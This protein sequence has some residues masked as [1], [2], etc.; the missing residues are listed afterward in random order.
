MTITLDEQMPLLPPA[1][2]SSIIGPSITTD[3]IDIRFND[4]KFAGH[5]I[6]GDFD[7][8]PK[9][10]RLCADAPVRA[11]APVAA[12]AECGIASDTTFVTIDP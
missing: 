2:A 9:L 7:H 8:R 10:G 6:S 11:G 1:A 5:T 12:R 4:A 3:A